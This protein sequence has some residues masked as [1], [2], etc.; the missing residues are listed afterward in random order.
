[1]FTSA[2]ERRRFLTLLKDTSEELAWECFAY[3]LMTNHYHVVVATPVPNISV[4]MHR[5]NSAYARWFNR[6]HGHQGHL[7]QARFHSALVEG[8]SHL[9]EACRYVLLNPVRA[10]IVQEASDWAWSSYR[11]TMDDE[12]QPAFHACDALLELFGSDA[13]SGRHNFERFVRDGQRR[14]GHSSHVQ[15][16]GTGTWL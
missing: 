7:F 1:M 10:G 6:S 14:P 13:E 4:G 15:V 9:L 3:C 12:G 11:S 5:L 16:P 8:D 2:G